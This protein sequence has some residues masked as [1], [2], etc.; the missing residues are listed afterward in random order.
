MADTAVLNG[1]TYTQQSNGTWVDSSGRTYQQN[2][3]ATPTVSNP[4]TAN[5]LAPTTP[6]TVTG[7]AVPGNNAQIV[8]GKPQ[9][10]DQIGV[11]Q[12]AGQI[13][14]DPK[15]L[16]GKESLLSTQVPTITNQQIQQGTIPS[17]AAQSPLGIGGI[18]ATPGQGTATTA[19]AP[20]Q[21]PTAQ[22]TAAQSADKVAQQD[23]TAAQGQVSNQSIID[24]NTVGNQQLGTETKDALGQAAQQNIS[25]LVDTT[26]LAGKILAETLGEGN[27]TDTKATVKG[28]LDILQGEFF[29]E[30][31]GEAKIPP[32]AAATARNVSKIAAFKGMSG[33][34]ATA[35]MAQALM[36]ASLPIAQQDAQFF[37]TLTIKNLDNRQEA[38]IN[39]ANV[40]AK[41]DMQ[42]ADAK[43]AVAINNSQAF[44]KM[45]M[46]NLDNRQ[47]A[48]II[49][50]Q[51]RVQS[52]LEDTKSE[53]VA[54]TF[55]AQSQNEMD[56]FYD[57]LGA[58]I[59]QFN[60]AQKNA[61][62]QFNAGE[63]TDVSKFNADMKNNR[64]QFYKEMQF[65]VD[66]SNAEWRQKVTLTQN[67]Q[68]FEAAA[69]DVKNLVGISVEQLNQL[70]DRSDALLDYAWKTADNT[71]ERNSRMAVA[72]LQ[73]EMALSAADSEGT[74]NILG[75]LLGTGAS[76]FF[77]WLF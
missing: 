7:A 76:Y 28:Q 39:K 18:T 20:T 37:Q 25:N 17:T 19:T 50:T 44:L 74:G 11:V 52:I 21:G 9:A 53:N 41:M 5:P 66:K 58:Q 26:T 51:N 38:T 33:T 16:L 60:A 63:R 64:D 73:G 70:W 56:M 62:E 77:D 68:Q 54:R 36:E 40:L 14:T 69:T 29:D 34:A 6:T 4:T 71:A 72:K 35:A 55:N 8:P 46:Q 42:N 45:D 43:L 3:A 24:P 2:Q 49:N 10:A 12:A 61:M 22:V 32:W 30:A 23:M 13:A 48:A 27:Y 31:T 57:N 15:L 67:A 1:V 47:Q 75:T 65:A 59:S